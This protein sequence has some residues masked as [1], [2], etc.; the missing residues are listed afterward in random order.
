MMKIE[1]EVTAKGTLH[2]IMAK[3]FGDSRNKLTF[4]SGTHNGV[5][6]T[7][8]EFNAL[9]ARAATIGAL[10]GFTAVHIDSHETLTT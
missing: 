10:R 1:F 9:G 8:E 4:K 5:A 3:C 6:I 2:R 7:G